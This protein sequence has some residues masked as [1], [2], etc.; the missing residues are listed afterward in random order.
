MSKSKAKGTR[1]ENLIVKL[2]TDLGI[3]A[4]RMPLSGSL[5]GKYS[6][7]VLIAGDCRAEVKARKNGEGF[8]TLEGWMKD[9]KLMFLKR[10][11]QPPLVVMTA[12]QYK[13]MAQKMW[14]AA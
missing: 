9:C 4:E 6:D 13:L 10:D 3:E 7:D 1:V 2:H 11:R 5:G 12:E 8:K 14:G